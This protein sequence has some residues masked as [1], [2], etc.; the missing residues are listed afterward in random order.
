NAITVLF[1]FLVSPLEIVA[2]L[3]NEAA[4]RLDSIGLNSREL[5]TIE[6]DPFS[7]S[8]RIDHFAASDAWSG[9]F[10]GQYWAS[11]Q[12]EQIARWLFSNQLDDSGSAEGI[13]L[14]LWRV[15]IGAGTLEQDSAYI[16]PFQRRAESSLTKDGMSFD[17]G[18]SSG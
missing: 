5:H 8:Q 16:S 6:I 13:G 12:K 10:V 17:W 2:Y 14:S 9:N 7:T 15:N 1:C 11:P 3:N 18:K 4:H